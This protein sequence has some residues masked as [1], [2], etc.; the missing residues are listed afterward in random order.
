MAHEEE[1]DKDASR[2]GSEGGEGRHEFVWDRFPGEVE[3][4]LRQITERE[5]DIEALYVRDDAEP[6]PW[7]PRVYSLIEQ[8]GDI[9][10]VRVRSYYG[11]D[12][13][14]G[15]E[16]RCLIDKLGRWPVDPVAGLVKP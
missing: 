14:W 3:R 8:H 10:E 1:R 7:G 11:L 4:L 16:N 6:E 13:G 5:P 9:I 2:E 12:E 15:Q